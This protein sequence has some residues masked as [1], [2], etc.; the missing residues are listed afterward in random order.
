M[1]R[2]RMGKFCGAGE[3]SDG[4]L[5]DQRSTVGQNLLRQL[6][7]LTRVNN[8]YS[9]AE[10]SYRFSLGIHRAAMGG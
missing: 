1:T 5:A 4:K 9:G 10:N 3:R 7:V 6:P 8:I 2:L